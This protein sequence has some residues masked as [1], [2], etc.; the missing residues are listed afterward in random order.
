MLVP[1]AVHLVVKSTLIASRKPEIFVLE[2]G[3]P[4]RIL[5]IAIK[6]IEAQGKVPVIEP[7]PDRELVEREVG[8]VFT[9]LKAGE[10]LTEELSSG[11]P[12]KPTQFAKIFSEDNEVVQPE[13]CHALTSSI[14]KA[15]EDNDVNRAL[16]L[17][18]E[19]MIGLQANNKDFVIKVQN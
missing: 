13:I 6:L 2:M 5:D 19:P 3:K 14:V 9:G 7:A 17:L 12:L 1:E 18:A 16:E 15:C 11:D 4:K 8:I 10:K